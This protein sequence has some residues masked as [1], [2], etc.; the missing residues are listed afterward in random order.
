MDIYDIL[1]RGEELHESEANAWYNG[2]VVG[3]ARAQEGQRVLE[4][5]LMSEPDSKSSN[6]MFY[7]ALKPV[8]AGASLL[9]SA[10]IGAGVADDLAPSLDD[11]V[12]YQANSNEDV[13]ELF[14]VDNIVCDDFYTRDYDRIGMFEKVEC[15]FDVTQN[16]DSEPDFYISF[17]DFNSPVEDGDGSGRV[18]ESGHI[19]FSSYD[20][21]T[22]IAPVYLNNTNKGELGNTIRHPSYEP[23]KDYYLIVHENHEG[24]QFKDKDGYFHPDNAGFNYSGPHK[25]KFLEEY[26]NQAPVNQSDDS[27][28]EE[29]SNEIYLASGVIAS[30]VLI[31]EILRRKKKPKEDVKSI[32]ALDS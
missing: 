26:F 11:V 24:F 12:V 20:K 22:V 6:S 19:S 14:T 18:S 23:N 8:L 7:R 30:G 3:I 25:L 5:E 16:N 27:I 29:F 17:I 32:V 10:I 2:D 4:S 1:E 13:E 31:S 9:T 15:S 28:F 21:K